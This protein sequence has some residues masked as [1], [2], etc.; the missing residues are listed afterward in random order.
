[1][2][3]DISIIIVNWNTRQLL[4]DC[5]DSLQANPGAVSCE[6]WVVDNASTDGSVE[7]L[8]ADYPHVNLIQNRA[9]VGFAR[10]N[11]QAMRK[12]S[13]RYLLLLNTDTRVTPGAVDAMLNLAEEKPQAGIVGACLFNADGSFQ[14]SYAEF[15]NLWREFLILS[16]LGRLFFGNFYPNHAPIPGEMPH[17]VDYVQ[18]ACLLVRREAYEEVGGLDEGYFMYSEEVDWCFAMRDA[19]WQIWYQP[20][21]AIIH[22]GGASS[23]SR[24]TARELDL[25]LS[26]V[27]FFRKHYGRTAALCLEIM[28]LYLTAVKYIFHRAARAVSRERVGRRVVSPFALAS[29]LRGIEA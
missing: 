6:I 15:P 17:P 1:M 8:R 25:Y 27:R 13:G 20:E 10:A 18:G 9:N 2:T 5:L 29:R 14:A 4:K 3:S 19:G 11:N 16:G 24:P 21:A 26:R 23:A 22:L 12:A 7:M 28:L